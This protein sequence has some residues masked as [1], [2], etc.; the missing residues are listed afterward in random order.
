MFGRWL[1]PRERQRGSVIVEPRSDPASDAALK[2]RLERQIQETL[3]NR[4][5][6]AEVRV[7]G[8]EV[9]IRAQTSRFWYHRNVKKSLE[10]LPNLSGY[11][12][13]VEVFD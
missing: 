5:R 6:N 4:I 7:M 2:R 1:G 3:G 8:R 9:F 10:S 13:Q 11:H 12:V